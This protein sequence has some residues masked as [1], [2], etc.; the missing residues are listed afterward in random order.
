[1]CRGE[2]LIVIGG[3]ALPESGI[4]SMMICDA[5]CCDLDEQAGVEKREPPS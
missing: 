5:T 1:V 4:G 2:R 3:D